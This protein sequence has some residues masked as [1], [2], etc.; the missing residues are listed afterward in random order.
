MCLDRD[1]VHWLMQLLAAMFVGH[2]TVW[3]VQSSADVKVQASLQFPSGL[4]FNL[5][6]CS[7][8]LK[9]YDM[10]TFFLYKQSTVSCPDLS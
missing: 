8:S 9:N 6:Q 10:N 1:L 7:V 4:M 2:S 5:L 3:E